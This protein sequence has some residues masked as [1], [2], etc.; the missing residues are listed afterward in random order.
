MYEGALLSHPSVAEH[1]VEELH[2]PATTPSIEANPTAS[3]S[4]AAATVRV[5]GR[6]AGAGAESIIP[7]TATAASAAK[8]ISDNA[9][10]AK[11]TADCGPNSELLS[12]TTTRQDNT[13]S[14]DNIDTVVD[15][16]SDDSDDDDIG[17]EG[18]DAVTRTDNHDSTISKV[19]KLIISSAVVVEKAAAGIAT[20][21]EIEAVAEAEVEAEPVML[22]LDTTGAEMA[23][24]SANEGSYRNSGEAFV[25][26]RHVLS[27]MD[28]KGLVARDIGVIT[29]YNGQLEVGGR[30]MAIARLAVECQNPHIVIQNIC[31][32][33]PLY[34]LITKFVAPSKCFYF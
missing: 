32:R 3:A 25:V 5:K 29:P 26:M 6:Q 1:T 13:D 7:A 23:E 27:L 8:S 19:S 22:L 21:A 9:E 16:A 24:E 34:C 10:V 18:Y 30:A 15:D 17:D 28:E 4:G 2:R 33:P 14:F 31:F 11:G 12:K 20:E